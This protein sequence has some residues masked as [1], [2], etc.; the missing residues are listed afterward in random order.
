MCIRDSIK[1]NPKELACLGFNVADLDVTFKKSAMQVSAYYKD[2]KYTDKALCDK[3]LQELR[4]SPNKIIDQFNSKT[5]NPL[6]KA[7]QESQKLGAGDKTAN[8]FEALGQMN[9]GDMQKA[10][11][12]WQAPPKPKAKETKNDPDHEEL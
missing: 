6:M 4:E 3:F 5:N 10:A 11:Q 1:K 12:D 8:P 7:F 2:V 9:M